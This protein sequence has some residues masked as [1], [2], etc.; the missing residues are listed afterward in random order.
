M[1]GRM[2]WG[3]AKQFKGMEAKYETGTVLRNGAMVVNER[4][5]ALAKRAKKVERQWLR[6]QGLD[7]KLKE[8]Q[9]K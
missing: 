9:L 4:P 6:Q 8:K 7:E 5:D 2:K 1:S 3:N